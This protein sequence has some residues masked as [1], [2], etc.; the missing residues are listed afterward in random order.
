LWLL[1]LIAALLLSAGF[2]A[3]AGQNPLVAGQA[4]LQGAVGSPVRV[5]ES[6]AKTIPLLMTGL[7]VTLSF[8]AG[9]WNIGAEGQFIMGAVAATALATKVLL[10]APLVL[11]GGA[12]AGGAWA[13]LAGWLKVRR[14]A[15]E[16]ITTI[17]LNYIALQLMVFS[18]Q[19]PLQERAR[20]QPQS[21]VFPPAT[22]LPALLANTTLHIG[23]W[24][25]ILSVLAV[26]WL[27]FRTESG[28][29]L[30]AAGANALASKAAGIEVER[31]TLRAVA[32]S[33]AL[34]GL[35]GAMELAGATK[36]LG[37]SPF[38]YGYTAIAVALLAGLNPIGVLFSALL[39]GLLNAGGGAMERTANVPAVTVSVITGLVIFAVALMPR[40]RTLRSD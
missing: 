25:A 9:F 8:R 31:V 27:L 30:R 40:L 39:F 19:G 4:L 22:Q 36:Q 10:P 16:I 24:L 15:P 33:G 38:G 13:L 1:P 21:D 17:M 14:G 20:T 18:V 37:S 2:V 11:L 5:A 12:L 26:W 28:F 6:L 35:G 23:L 29:L 34:A 7:A 3:L 32:A